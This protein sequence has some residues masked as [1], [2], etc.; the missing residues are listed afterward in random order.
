MKPF[1]AIKRFGAKVP[2]AVGTGLLLASMHVHAALPE[3]IGTDVA[4]S[5]VDL[6]EAGALFISLTLVV[7]F[8]VWLRRVMK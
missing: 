8:F 2:A 3:A 1:N 5:K 7:L 6:K 4:S